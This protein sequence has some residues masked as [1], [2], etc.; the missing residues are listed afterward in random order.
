M[1]CLPLRSDR[2]DDRFI[3]RECTALRVCYQWRWSRHEA[4][5]RVGRST[6]WR[7]DHSR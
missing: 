6:G 7:R 3:S 5:V 2:T 1:G 4:D